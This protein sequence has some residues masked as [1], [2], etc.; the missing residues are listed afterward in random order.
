MPAEPRAF[1]RLRAVVRDWLAEPGHTQRAL[2]EASGV[3][4]PTISDIANGKVTTVGLDT[5]EALTAIVGVPGRDAGDDDTAPAGPVR[6]VRL[7]DLRANPGNPR[8][9]IADGA[10]AALARSIDDVGLLQPLR[11]APWPA[12]ED[13]ERFVVIAGNT[14]LAVLADLSDTWD[15][16]RGPCPRGLATDADG[17]WLVPVL[18][19]DAD[20]YADSDTGRAAA[21][22]DRLLDAL[23]ENLARADLNPA[24]E[25]AAYR[26]LVDDHGVTTEAVASAV[27]R[28]QRHVQGY[29]A[30]ARKLAPEALAA[31]GD[32]RLGPAAARVLVALLPDGQKAVLAR[33]LL[34]GDGTSEAAARTAIADFQG[35]RGAFAVPGRPP[36]NA[37]A[38]ERRS[39]PDEDDADAALVDRFVSDGAAYEAGRKARRDGAPE[40]DNPCRAGPH[41]RLWAQGYAAQAAEDEKPDD[42]DAPTFADDEIPLSA[43]GGG[44]GRGE[45]GATP[46]GTGERRSPEAARADDHFED[47]EDDADLANFTDN[48]DVLGVAHADDAED[49]DLP[50]RIDLALF[51]V[52]GTYR[53][54]DDQAGPWNLVRADGNR[55]LLRQAVAPYSQVWYVAEPS[56]TE[57][58]RRGA[59]AAEDARKVRDALRD[60]WAATA[61]PDDGAGDHPGLGAFIRA[62]LA[63]FFATPEPTTGDPTTAPAPSSP[64]GAEPA[65]E[66]APAASAAPSSQPGDWPDMPKNL[67]RKKPGAGTAIAAPADPS[68][69]QQQPAGKAGTDT[70]A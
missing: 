42:A 38:G 32:G 49:G 20:E 66:A 63:G 55:A 70:L 58:R 6:M 30:L 36:A 33:L 47:D 31:L 12:G 46:A 14:R 15:E 13:G 50:A 60:V 61:A 2:A 16:A 28:T 57:T 34:A 62:R 51:G 43:P 1:D 64:A 4:Q 41:R 5:A 26:A 40:T 22:R 8:T 65:A 68:G 52:R 23:A 54:A 27:G 25:A 44:E 35:R 10:Y 11:V 9:R 24:D 48:V 53:L 45:V 39:P 19:D 37:A 69:P 29:A 67:R 7:A 21:T 56:V 17:R 59:E 18:V 3:A